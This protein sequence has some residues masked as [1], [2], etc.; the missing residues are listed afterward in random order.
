MA[1]Q[2]GAKIKEARAAAGLSQKVLAEKAGCVTATDISKAERDLK[3]LTPEQLE[4]VAQALG[5]TPE[6]LT[7]APPVL[8]DAEV[9]LLKLYDGVITWNNGEIDIAPEAVYQKSYAYSD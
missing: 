9:E 2:D 3:E 4:A 1:K 6:S 5:V 7:D 8:S